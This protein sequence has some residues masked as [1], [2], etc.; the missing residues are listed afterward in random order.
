MMSRFLEDKGLRKYETHFEKHSIRRGQLRDLN[1]YDLIAMGI[2]DKD[3]RHKLVHAIR[4]TAAEGGGASA[5][6]STVSAVPSVKVSDT[7]SG[8]SVNESDLDDVEHSEGDMVEDDPDKVDVKVGLGDAVRVIRVNPDSCTIEELAMCIAAAF[9]I[10]DPNA[11]K[12]K[13]LDFEGDLIQLKNQDD[14]AYALMH[15]R[16]KSNIVFHVFKKDDE[17]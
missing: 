9:S 5:S 17:T 13:L 10:A 7:S 15:C 3:D 14:L 11:L 4:K 8:A 2:D 12:I 1:E 16:G 6:S